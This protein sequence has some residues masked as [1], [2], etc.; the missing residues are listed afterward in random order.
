MAEPILVSASKFPEWAMPFKGWAPPTRHTR[1]LGMPTFLDDWLFCNLAAQL[2]G[3]TAREIV[4]AMLR[5]HG[6]APLAYCLLQQDSVLREVHMR[7]EAV[8]ECLGNAEILRANFEWAARRTLRCKY[9]RRACDKPCEL[10][11]DWI[12]Q[13]HREHEAKPCYPWQL[14]PIAIPW[15]DTFMMTRQRAVAACD[16]ARE[17]RCEAC[18]HVWLEIAKPTQWSCW[19]AECIIGPNLWGPLPLPYTI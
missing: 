11:C 5:C 19:G 18:C 1:E 6:Y 12:V 4:E 9:S 8:A 16:F 15:H 14:S 10:P 7:F 2:P 13:R 17:C 3:T